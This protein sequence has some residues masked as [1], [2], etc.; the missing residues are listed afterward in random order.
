MGRKRHLF[1]FSGKKLPL[2]TV[3]R[4]MTVKDI[5]EWSEMKLVAK[6]MWLGEDLLKLHLRNILVENLKTDYNQS[7]RSNFYFTGSMRE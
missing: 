4:R 7:F 5:E 6:Q 1:V 3:I 2:D